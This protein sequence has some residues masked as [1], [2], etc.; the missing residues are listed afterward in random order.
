VFLLFDF[1]DVTIP[2][3]PTS[4]TPKSHK[5]SCFLPTSCGTSKLASLTEDVEILPGIAGVSAANLITIVP[6]A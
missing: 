5:L 1:D 3:N 2:P 6:T 4:T